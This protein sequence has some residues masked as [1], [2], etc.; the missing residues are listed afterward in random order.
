M[1]RRLKQADK[2]KACRAVEVVATSTAVI[3]VIRM[4]TNWWLLRELMDSGEPPAHQSWPTKDL[5]SCQTTNGLELPVKWADNRDA[6]RR[7]RRVRLSN[8]GELVVEV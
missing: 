6:L 3:S 1:A 4:A 7:L 2:M 8:N 5:P